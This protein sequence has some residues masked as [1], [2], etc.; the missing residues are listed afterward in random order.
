MSSSPDRSAGL[1]GWLHEPLPKVRRDGAERAVPPQATIERVRPLLP[2]LGITR[3]AN[4]T[5]LDR[6]GIPTTSVFRPNSRSLAVSQGKGL[7]LDAAI[8]SGVMEALELFHAERVFQPIKLASANEL[9]WM[10]DI[11]DLAALPPNSARLFHPDR[12]LLWIESLDL[13]EGY[14]VWLPFES[15]HLDSTMPLPTGSGC[16]D[17]SSNGLASGNHPLEAVHHALCELIER[18]AYSHYREAGP[19]VSDAA[20]LDLTTVDDPA[21][22]EI[23]EKYA[24]AEIDVAVWDMTS[25]LGI[26][27]FHCIIVE[28]RGHGWRQIAATGGMGCHPSRGVALLRA[29]TEAA[30]SRLTW[31]SGTRDDMMRSRHEILQGADVVD[32]MRQDMNDQKPVRSFADVPSRESNDIH[33]DVHG[34]LGR[35]REN[36]L[37]QALMVDLTHPA[38]S[39]PVVKMVVPGLR[40][41]IHH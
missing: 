34:L 33:D 18:D 11:V 22:I 20:R 32:Q 14:P 6:I 4:I 30:Q 15:V 5:G 3:I 13:Q 40:G 36:G 2:I 39:I 9:Q 23:L 35:L 10:E 27:A 31:I 19:Q 37:E 28:R 26:A 29:L 17:Q 24:A 41:I 38:L 8:A 1:P 25:R 7:T 16:F 21:C 12:R